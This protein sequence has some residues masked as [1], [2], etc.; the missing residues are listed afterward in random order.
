MDESEAADDRSKRGSAFFSNSL[1]NRNFFEPE[2]GW[3]FLLVVQFQ[4]LGISHYITLFR[5]RGRLPRASLSR[6]V[7]IFYGAEME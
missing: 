4:V 7:P 5:F 2:V 6:I 3:F 1:L